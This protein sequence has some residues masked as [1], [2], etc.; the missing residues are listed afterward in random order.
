MPDAKYGDQEEQHARAEHGGERL[1]P[2]V[3][4]GQH[5]REGEEGVD[6][7]AR[8]QRDRIVGVKRH[9]Q[10]ADG[11]GNAG[12]DE[13][14][15]LV[16]PRLSEND[17]VHEDDVDHRQKRGHAGNEFGADVGALLRKAEIAVQRGGEGSL[18]LCVCPFG[19]VHPSSKRPGANLTRRHWARQKRLRRCG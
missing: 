1:L 18:I 11:R 5:H 14:R 16:H 13:D 6:A 7:H 8:R 12:R 2:G 9:H 19:H 17:G 15:A 4:V 10:S 3:L